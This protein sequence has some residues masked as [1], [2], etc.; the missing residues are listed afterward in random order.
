MSVLNEILATKRDEITV[1]RSPQTR[2]L[3]RKSALNAE[4]PRDFFGALSASD[5]HL[6]VISE[7]KRKSPSKGELAS[8]LNPRTMAVSY[9]QGGAAAMSVLTDQQYFGGSVADL[10]NA[11]AAMSIPVLRKD[12]I[13]DEVQIY[14]SR[15]IGADAILLILAAIAEDSLLMDLQSLAQ[16]LGMSVLVEAHS[17]DEVERAIALDVEILGVNARNLA[18]F[19]EDREGVAALASQIPSGFVA[20]AESAIRSLEDAAKMADA[21]FNAVLVGEALVRHPDP[22]S[23]VAAMSAVSV[24]PR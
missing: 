6:R 23:L 11:R 19:A 13:I 1:L 5:S 22:S 15:A 2:D 18:D 9:A 8:N 3:L 12:F 14:E 24:S 20:V 7:F 16:S 10:Q 17:A 21:G 4:P